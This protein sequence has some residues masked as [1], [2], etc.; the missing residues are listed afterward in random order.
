MFICLNNTE[1]TAAILN[2][3]SKRGIN[4][5]VDSKTNIVFITAHEYQ[6]NW[7]RAYV[8]VDEGYLRV[9]NSLQVENGESKVDGFNIPFAEIMTIYSVD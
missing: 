8:R 4:L 9:Y 5:T 7:Y 1:N 3:F 2:E 6:L